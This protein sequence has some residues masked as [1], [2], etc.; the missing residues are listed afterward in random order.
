MS[1]VDF[2]ELASARFDHAVHRK[3]MKERIEAQLV[4]A[5][6]GGV[7]K[8]TPE[9]ISFLSIWEDDHV[10]LED[11][12]SN[13]VEVNRIQLLASLRGAYRYAMN[14]WHNEFVESKKVR[15]LADV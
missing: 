5:H 13:P 4:V 3:A 11:I 14:A 6:G 10:F 2:A 1:I 9:L 8:A 15:K 12:Y 7:F